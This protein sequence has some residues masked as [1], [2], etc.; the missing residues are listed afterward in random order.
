M[1]I[2]ACSHSSPSSIPEDK[3]VSKHP[4]DINIGV[5][6]KDISNMIENLVNHNPEPRL[7][8]KGGSPLFDDNFD[9]GEQQRIQKSAIPTLIKNAEE[10]WP[11]LVKHLDDER[12][13][14][15]AISISDY[16]HNM[17]VG[18][19]CRKIIAENLAAAYLSNMN[20]TK[21][22]VYARFGW[23]SIASERILKEWCEKR[24]DK[25]LFELQIE[26]CKWAI[27]ELKKSEYDKL[28]TQEE[29]QKW[30]KS[31]TSEIVVLQKNQKAVPYN[32]F[33]AEEFVFYSKEEAEDIKKSIQNNQNHEKVKMKGENH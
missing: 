23:P 1:F 32:G 15:T 16:T 6:N 18:Y 14:I 17:T 5:A 8:E 4:K 11:D 28:V 13:C 12:Y 3:K 21:K 31:I 27:E 24:R 22:S 2:T 10:A 25:K 19:I 33:G 30:I 7:V 20:I 29:R 9:W 26:M